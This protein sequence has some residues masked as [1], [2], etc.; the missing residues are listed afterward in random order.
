[1]RAMDVVVRTTLGSL[2]F[3]PVLQREL[4]ALNPRIPVANLRSMS[5]VVNQANAQT[6]F[7]MAMLGAS[8]G[9]A[10]LLGLVGIYGVVS[11]L[12]SLRRREIGVR[13]A[14]GATTTSVRGM[15]VR[16]GLALGVGGVA[17]GL[18]AAGF[19]SS[20]MSSLLFG[21]RSLDPATYLSVS[22]ALVTVSALASWLPARRAAGVDPSMA[23]RED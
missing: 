16:E 22:V 7:T 8:A 15:V 11:Y 23:L 17:L 20:L 9:I 3:L 2:G 10:L 21:V 14:L 19:L 4:N 18:I 12:V 1:M 13:M 6:S 5:A